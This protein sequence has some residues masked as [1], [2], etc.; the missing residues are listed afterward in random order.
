MSYTIVADIC[1]GVADCIPVCPTNCMHRSYELN[2][3]G[4]MFTYIDNN[5]CTD[6]GACLS[7]CPVEGAIIDEWRPEL[8]VSELRK[9]RENELIAQYGES[10]TVIKILDRIIEIGD[11]EKM[12]RQMFGDPEDVELLDLDAKE[13]AIW[14]YYVKKRI[15]S[16]KP[17]VIR[18]H[19]LLHITFEDG[20][21]VDWNDKR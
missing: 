12:V 2:A 20:Q 10:A 15:I 3:K 13:K 4:C 19:F 9:R 17:F 8:Q 14:K 7:V 16:I 21:V 6:C 1:E 18:S 11:S 5:N